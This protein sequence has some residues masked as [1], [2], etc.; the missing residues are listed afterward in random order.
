MAMEEA[1]IQIVRLVL[2]IVFAVAAQYLAIKIFDKMTSR[3]DEMEE[4]K[5]G[6]VAIGIVLGSVILSVATI[7]SGGVVNIVPSSFTDVTNVNF[8]SHL[9]AGAL[10]LV[11]AIVFAVVAQFVAL[12]VFD[13]MTE[14][15]DEQKELKKGNLAI[16]ILLAAVI[17]ATAI[18]VQAGLPS[19]SFG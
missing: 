18:V 3:I 7:I 14:G 17:Y 11:I 12:K 15:I 10:N 13:S 16:A 4:L 8:F 9:G 2:A 19:F 5:K 6:N 1:L